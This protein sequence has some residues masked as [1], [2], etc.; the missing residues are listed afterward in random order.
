MPGWM[1]LVIA[2]LVFAHGVAYL[3]YG[4]VPGEVV[5]EWKGSSRLLGRVLTSDS[6]HTDVRVLFLTAGAAMVAVAVAIAL[7]PW[8]P[9]WWRPFAILGSLAGIAGFA[10]FWDG[11]RRLLVKEGVIGLALSLV[12]LS[13]AV[14]LPRAFG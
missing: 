7:D 9:G 14:A 6:V 10:T 8:V 11:Q 1:R 2:V 4:F 3:P 12:L 13:V 5:K